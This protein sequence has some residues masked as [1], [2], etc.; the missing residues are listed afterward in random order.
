MWRERKYA[1][2]WRGGSRARGQKSLQIPYCIPFGV[3]RICFHSAFSLC[4]SKVATELRIRNFTD[5]R[6]E[7]TFVITFRQLLIFRMR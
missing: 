1:N 5:F 4:A 7:I 3:I 6:T 2:T